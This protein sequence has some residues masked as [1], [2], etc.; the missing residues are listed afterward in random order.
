LPITLSYACHDREEADIAELIQAWPELP[1][2]VQAAI[3]A[4]VESETRRK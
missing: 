4:M 3:A 2:D 1:P